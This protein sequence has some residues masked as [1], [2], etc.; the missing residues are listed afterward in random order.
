MMKKGIALIVLVA[1]AG[2]GLFCLDLRA[3][4]RPGGQ[5]AK[6][7]VY[8][9][10]R[11]SARLDY[12][13][14]RSVDPGGIHPEP[15]ASSSGSSS[16]TWMYATAGIL[17]G[18]ALIVIGMTCFDPTTEDGPT[19]QYAFIAGGAVTIGGSLLIWALD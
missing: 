1:V 18:V 15:M 14:V 2:Q 16:D 3:G 11:E 4:F 6:T 12:L 5:P 10:A 13:I 7:A 17:G 9:E 8:N 19:Y